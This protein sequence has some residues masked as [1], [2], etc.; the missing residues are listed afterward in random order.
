MSTEKPPSQDKSKEGIKEKL[1]AQIAEAEKKLHEMKQSIA[2]MGEHAKEALSKKRDELQQR[3]E[4]H[5]AQLKE[6]ESAS[7]PGEKE[8]PK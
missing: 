4:Q 6:H 3:L 2:S 1:R 7:Q 8:Q 5:K